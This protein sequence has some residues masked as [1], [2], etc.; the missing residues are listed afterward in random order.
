MW[1]GVD[2][3][4]AVIIQFLFVLLVG[5]CGMAALQIARWMRP[6]SKLDE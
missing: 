4:L 3:T 1:R 5:G 2:V 6:P